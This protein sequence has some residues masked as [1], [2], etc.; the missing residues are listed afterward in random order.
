[1]R[2]EDWDWLVRYA[3]AGGAIEIVPEVLAIVNNRRGRLGAETEQAASIFLRKHA[4][5]RARYGA[6]F[7]RRAEVDVWMQVAGTYAYARKWRDFTRIYGR[8]FMMDPAYCA[9]RLVR[10]AW[11]GGQR[12]SAQ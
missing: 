3:S 7:A 1:V 5:L 2:F 8:A 9:G 10:A 4:A 6:A 11:R 12:K